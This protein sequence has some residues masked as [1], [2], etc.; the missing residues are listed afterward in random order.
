VN[1]DGINDIAIMPNIYSGSDF[2]QLND[3]AYSGIITGAGDLNGD[4]FDDILIAG[5]GADQ[6]FVHL[7]EDICNL[8][9]ECDYICG[10]A[11]GNKAVNILDI[12][13]LIAYLY[14][15]GPP[16]IPIEAGDANGNG[17]VNILDITYLIA[18]LYS[19]GPE[20]VCPQ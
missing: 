19:G 18:Y 11:N 17:A 6:V 20:P 5:Y 1:G 3:T 12:T 9:P 13:Y 16:P 10:D 14:S 8:T 15:S 2:S 4:C 7:I